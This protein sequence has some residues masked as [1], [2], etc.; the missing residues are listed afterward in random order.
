MQG[1]TVVITGATSGIGEVAATSL[2]EAGARVVF[3]A[4]DAAK[5]QAMLERLVRANPDS[6][7]A[8]VEAELSTLAGMKAAG[9]ALAAKAPTIDV[10]ANNAG[11][12]FDHRE[13][14]E[15]G[16][17]KTFA[18]NHMAYFVITECLRPNLAPSARIVST[19]S[20]AHQF[21]RLD[22]DDLQ[23]TG[24]YRAMNAYGASKLCNILWTHE[25]ARRLAGTGI[26][27]NCFHP[28]AVNTGF[29]HNT[30]GFIKIALGLISR[31]MLTPAQGAD[32]LI[33][34]ASSPAIEGK[35]G[36]YYAKR[37]LTLPSAAARDGTAGK[38]L[39]DESARIAGLAETIPT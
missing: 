16:L 3:V 32:T 9:A 25:L 1:K 24:R 23:A 2:A 36:G 19:A 12:I 22:F 11:A 4:R 27:A 37:K 8:F 10:L 29:G 21:G 33:W 13:V 20:T 18:V 15:D 31:F 6:A 26:T 35:T 5:G 28:G 14:T 7:H 38:R 39:W 30:R 34:L 17:E